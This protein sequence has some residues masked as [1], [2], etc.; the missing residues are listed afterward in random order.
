MAT[1]KA[2]HNVSFPNESTEYRR[3]RNRLL[4]SEME[5][6][7]QIEA[8]SAQRRK[9]PLGGGMSIDYVFESSMPDY[10]ESG[11]TRI[12]ELFGPRKNTLFIYNF[13]YPEAVGSRTPCPSCTSMIDALDGAAQ[14]VVQRTNFAV[15]AKAPIDKFRQHAR[16]R[17]WRHVTLLSSA[18]NTFN[19]DYHAEESGG[20]QLPIAHVFARRGKKVRH[21]WSSEL[22][23][24]RPDRGLH[25]RHVDFMW[26]MWSMFDRTPEGRGT[27]WYPSQSYS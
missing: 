27:N 25:A 14:H 8:V 18:D 15:I 7:R 4:R 16:N 10:G 19:S 17:G 24:V 21:F 20:Q 3:A 2:L 9:L 26:P 11:T 12:S 6:R 1:I 13:M 5:L 22:F 23:F